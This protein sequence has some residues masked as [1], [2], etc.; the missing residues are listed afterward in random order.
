MRYRMLW[1]GT[2]LATAIAAASC[3]FLDSQTG[4]LLTGTGSAVEDLSRTLAARF[5]C[6][7]AVIALFGVAAGI[8]SDECRRWQYWREMVAVCVLS[9]PLWHYA[10]L[11]AQSAR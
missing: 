3:Q 8:L 7:S 10:L 9:L 1:L 2:M 11:F 6:L 5:L 4:E